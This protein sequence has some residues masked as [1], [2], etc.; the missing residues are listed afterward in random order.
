MSFST[1]ILVE[2]VS[3]VLLGLFSTSMWPCSRWRRM[4]SSSTAP[5]G[6]GRGGGADWYPFLELGQAPRARVC[7]G[8][9]HL[10]R[11]AGDGGGAKRPFEFPIRPGSCSTRR[12]FKGTRRLGYVVC[13]GRDVCLVRWLHH[14]SYRQR[15]SDVGTVSVP[16]PRYRTGE[17]LWGQNRSCDTGHARDSVLA[18]VGQNLSRKQG[19]Q[20]Q[21][22]ASARRA[23]H[24]DQAGTRTMAIPAMGSSS[25][26]FGPTRA[27]EDG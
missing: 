14:T 25:V 8:Y 22:C 20:Q 27:A 10:S 13:Y 16:Y 15:V 2:L 9:G 5:T 24:G 21:S 23:P 7:A 3:G 26:G 4:G 12:T 18:P 11:P 19:D 6:G 17:S 1:K